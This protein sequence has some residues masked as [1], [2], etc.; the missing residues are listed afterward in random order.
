[1]DTSPA[2]VGLSFPMPPPQPLN[3]SQTWPVPC[4]HLLERMPRADSAC[5]SPPCPSTV[6]GVSR[7]FHICVPDEAVLRALPDFPQM[8]L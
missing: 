8:E 3:A 5:S 7:C 2:S 6:H 4:S 1:M